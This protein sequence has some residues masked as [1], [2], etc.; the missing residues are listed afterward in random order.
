MAMTHTLKS[1][2]EVTITMVA[3][4]DGMRGAIQC[5]FRDEATDA[6]KE[7]ANAFVIA[8]FIPPGAREATSE[9]AAAR[10]MKPLNKKFQTDEE[11]DAHVL[12]FL[13]RGQKVN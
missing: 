3:S 6:D 8:T 4:H 9:E 10:G 12:D 7:E 1:G 11:L 2:N 5:E 13:T